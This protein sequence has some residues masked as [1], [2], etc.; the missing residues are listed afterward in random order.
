MGYVR[1]LP[2]DAALRKLW[3]D[4]CTTRDA[5][6][7]FMKSQLTTEE[8]AKREEAWKNA[9]DAWVDTTR[10]FVEDAGDLLPNNEAYFYRLTNGKTYRTDQ[11]L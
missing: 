2:S 7:P 4:Y 10:G 5:S 6:S 9:F 1:K 3:I 8:A 11:P